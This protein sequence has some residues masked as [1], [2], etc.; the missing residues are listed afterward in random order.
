MVIDWQDIAAFVTVAAA[1]TW[2]ARGC[3]RW[4]RGTRAAGCPSC[5]GCAARSAAEAN[6]L[7]AI[8][9]LAKD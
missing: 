8:Q 1:M 3:W 6:Q 5:T 9:P 2:L 4:L 7:I